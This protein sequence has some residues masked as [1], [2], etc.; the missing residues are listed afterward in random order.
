MS[1]LHGIADKGTI[2]GSLSGIGQLI[3]NMTVPKAVYSNLRI[4]T[5]AEWN[6]QRD[7][8]GAENTVYMY[9]D[10]DV[11]EEGNFI[12]AFK[13]G[14]GKAYLIDLPFNNDVFIRHVKNDALH[15]TDK[16]REFWNNKVRAY[17]NAENLEELILT[18]F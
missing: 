12:P 14:D 5:T 2:S 9:T 11:D 8:I 13:I 18:K 15:V 4:A 16:E 1:E 17:V 3:G 7:L 6:A 10:H